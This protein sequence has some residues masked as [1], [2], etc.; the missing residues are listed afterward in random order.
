MR[1]GMLAMAKQ[2]KLLK[3]PEFPDYFN[4]RIV[5][6]PSVTKEEAITMELDA[7]SKKL[8]L[9]A[10]HWGIP[11]DNPHAWQIVCLCLAE[12]CLN[13][14]QVSSQQ[15]RKRGRSRDLWRA[16]TLI[17]RVNELIDP[18]R[19]PRSLSIAEACGRLIE[20]DPGRWANGRTGKKLEPKTLQN[21]YTEALKYFD[22]AIE[23][24]DDQPHTVN[25]QS[26]RKLDWKLLGRILQSRN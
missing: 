22:A 15:D 14:F 9:L 2:A 6:P 18:N 16:L 3:P 13:G 5:I 26:S 20:K 23:M 12:T 1:R 17:A 11:L 8:A 25:Q 7:K 21:E 19:A 10:E 24:V 4:E